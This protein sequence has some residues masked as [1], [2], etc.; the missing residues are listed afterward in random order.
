M[1]DDYVQEIGNSDDI[2]EIVFILDKSG[3]MQGLEKDTIGGFNSMLE[4]Q[5]K[6]RGLAIVTTVLFDNNYHVIHNRVP[7]KDVQRMTERD[8]FAGGTTALL[9]AIG[10]TANNIMFAHKSQKNIIEKVIFIII[11]DGLE[12]S[13]VEYTYDGTRKL[14]QKLKKEYGWEF[15]LIGANMDAVLTANRFGIDKNKAVN[16]HADKVG[17]EL[18]FKTV[19]QVLSDVR[20]GIEID[21]T[22]KNDIE[23]DYNCRNK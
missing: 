3:S 17:T 13:S 20:S 2:T 10:I 6:Q 8:Y 11:T 16:Y 22:W 4:K 15:I 14:I 19:S 21:K 18:N 1:N 7:L 23:N 12:N 9:D 5:K